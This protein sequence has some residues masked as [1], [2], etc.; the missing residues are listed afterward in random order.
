MAMPGRSLA[1]GALVALLAA[2]TPGCFS[3]TPHISATPDRRLFEASP[4]SFIRE[5]E[6]TRETILLRLGNPASRYEGDRI[7]V[8]QVGFESDGRVHIYA[9]RILGPLGLQDWE[10]GS[11]SFVLVFRDDGVL[12]EYSLVGTE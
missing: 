11:Y 12:R 10:R 2:A 6:T 7:L 9:P 8:Y 3:A 1:R 5:G 4:L